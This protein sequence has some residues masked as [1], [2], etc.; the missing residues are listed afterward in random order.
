MTALEWRLGVVAERLTVAR[1]L[2]A[3]WPEYLMEAWGLGTFMLSAGLFATLLEYPGSPIR[4]AIEDGDLRRGLMGL[5]M[6]L[7]AIVIIYSPWGKRSG[8]HIN[9]AVTLS[10]WRLGKVKPVDALF[11]VLAQFLGGAL[12]VAIVWAILGATFAEP[13]VHFVNTFPGPAGPGVAY[14]VEMGM[15]AGLMLMV[16]VSLASDRLMPFIG[17]FAGIMVATYITLLAPLSGMGINPARS[18]ASA[19]PGGLWD[20][21]WIYLTAPVIG[22]LAAVEGHRLLGRSRKWF[23][24]KLNHDDAYRCIHCGHDPALADELACAVP[25]A[26]PSATGGEKRE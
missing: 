8:A 4:S 7:T 13:P 2:R 22:M 3:H 15:A 6:G 5:A 12:G 17:L 11:Y 19:L 18:F 16:V 26:A 24:A 14:L 1:A 23:C 10:F 20:F 25:G 21:L 9:P